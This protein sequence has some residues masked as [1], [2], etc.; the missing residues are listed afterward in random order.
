M[1]VYFKWKKVK[2]FFFYLDADKMT[3]ITLSDWLV[4]MLILCWIWL[5]FGTKRLS[6]IMSSDDQFELG[7]KYKPTCTDEESFLSEFH[8]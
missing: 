8:L 1:K 5:N 3:L 6:F 7:E 4:F 2:Q